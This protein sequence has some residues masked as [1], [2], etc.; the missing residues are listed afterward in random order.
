MTNPAVALT[1]RVRPEYGAGQ[2]GD[3]LGQRAGAYQG[4]VGIAVPQPPLDPLQPILQGGCFK[5]I[6]VRQALGVLTKHGQPHGNV[7]PIQVMLAAGRQVARE[8]ANAVTAVGQHRDRLILR[9]PLAPQ[10]LAEPALRCG[11]LAADEAEVAVVAILGHRFADDDLEV[12]LLV[13]PVP[14][15]ATIDPDNDC[16]PRDR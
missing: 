5:G 11:I 8:R 7:E 6:V 15:V 9:Q 13:M 14:E 3:I 2:G 16:L 10:H 4:L 12:P 1:S